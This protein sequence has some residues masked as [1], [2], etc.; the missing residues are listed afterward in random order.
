MRHQNLTSTAIYTLVADERRA[1]GI[2]RL[3][4]FRG[5]A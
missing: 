4:P 1:D 5:A 3:D 2:D